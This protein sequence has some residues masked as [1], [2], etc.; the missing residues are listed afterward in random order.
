TST[1][2][3]RHLKKQFGLTR[4]NK[5]GHAGTLDPDATG[6]LIACFGQATKLVPWL[7]ADEKTYTA[8]GKLGAETLTDD[9]AG[10][11]ILERAWD[12]V[13]DASLHAAVGTFSGEIQ[14]RPPRVSALKLGG[15][16]LY[17]RVRRGENIDDEIEARPVLLHRLEVADVSLPEFSL[18]MVVGKGFYVRSLVRDVARKLDTAAH[19]TALRRTA[20]GRYNVSDAHSLDAITGDQLIPLEQAVDHL[21]TLRVEGTA[22]EWL[23]NGRPFAEGDDATL[24]AGTPDDADIRALGP[25]GRLMAIV[26]RQDNGTFSVV[27]GFQNTGA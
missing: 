4:R 5:L 3:L 7:M 10:D 2:V 25:D 16:R 6:L 20:V 18:S 23:H 11:V 12:H 8:T 24:D 1:G 21:P 27:R 14:Q 26:S 9:A 22:A 17:E 15:E 19:V 13:T